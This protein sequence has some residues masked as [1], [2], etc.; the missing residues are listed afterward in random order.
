MPMPISK[1]S[2]YADPALARALDAKH[3]AVFGASSTA[4]KWGYNTTR[5]ILQAGFGGRLTLVNPRGGEVFDRPLVAA[6]EAAGADLAV[7]CTPAQTVPPIISQCGDLEIPVA[8]V[9]AGGFGE[10]G[11]TAL[12]EELRRGI[13]A[14]GVRVIGPNCVGLYV[15]PSGVNTT[16]MTHFKSGHVSVI[17]QSGGVAQQAARR[18]AELG[19]GFD[20]MLALGNKLDVDMSASLSVMSERET[21]G[22]IFLYLERL[23]EGEQLLDTLARITEYVP[24]VALLAGR[25]PAGRSAAL[26]HTGSILGEWDRVSGLLT[27]AGVMVAE[28]LHEACAAV[29]GG[30]RAPRQAL[31]RVFVICDGGG[32]SALLAD[33]L[34]T[35]GHVVPPPSER[36]RAK[37]QKIGG[38]GGTVGNPF[39]SQGR[40]DRDPGLYLPLLQAVLDDHDHDA[41][42][43]GGMFGGY[44]LLFD[45][46]LGALEQRTAKGMGEAAQ[47]SGRRII[48]QSLYATEPS[49]SLAALRERGVACVEWPEEVLAVLRSCGQPTAPVAASSAQGHPTAVADVELAELTE[50]LVSAMTRRGIRHALGERIALKNLPNYSGASWVLRLD[51]FAHKTRAGAIR[52][53]VDS[54][55][56]PAAY[57]E[58][59]DVA[60]AAGIEPLVRMAPM[61]DTRCELLVTFWRDAGSGGGLVL[62]LGGVDVEEQRDVAI[63]RLPK[64]PDDVI[65]LLLR[66]RVGRGLHAAG[67]DGRLEEIAATVLALAEL[68]RDDLP[69]VRELECNPLAVGPDGVYVLDALPTVG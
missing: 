5:S 15:G 65:A 17:T 64:G 7:I 59:A 27:D 53:G 43:I 23:D 24:V 45:E 12:D 38:E 9:Q 40:L 66:T 21:T 29:V 8:V 13:A 39:D 69:S 22:A 56:L 34:E 6:P 42:V 11:N 4:G 18:L 49:A 68:F 33:A 52:V 30:R 25:T 10:V 20:V 26:S 32:H 54:E 28:G 44:E 14:S 50:V 57:A 16:T 46:E 63:G 51:G 31:D 36:L 58:L 41:V 47:R 37:L 62:G 55:E 67:S 1:Q 60:R 19:T 61:I 48:V 35:A 3:I 2:R